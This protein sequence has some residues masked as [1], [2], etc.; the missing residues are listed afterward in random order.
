MKAKVSI[1][2]PVYNGANYMR[3]AIDSALAQSYE[4]TEIIVVNDG[5]VDNTEKIALSYGNKI[6]YFSK[7]NG[8]VSSALN[9]GIANMTGDYFQYLPHDDLLHPD[10]IK[11]QMEAIQKS[12]NRMSIAWSGWNRFLESSHKKLQFQIP[13]WYPRSCWT[14]RRYPLF[15]GILNTVT[16]LLHKR[17]FELVGTF[18]ETLR[19][20]QDYD[21]WFRTFGMNDTVY[22]DKP[23]VDYRIHEIQGT[24]SD[25]EFLKNCQNLAWKILQRITIDEIKKE[26]SSE[27]MCFYALMKYYH[28]VGWENHKLYVLQRFIE[29]EAPISAIKGRKQLSDEL[30]G[31]G[32]QLVL[33][34]AGKNGRRL[35]KELWAYGI[36]A[37]AFCDTNPS[38]TGSEIW[39]VKCIS[40]AELTD[41]DATII[42]TFD[43]PEQ[44]RKE[45][46]SQ[47]LTRV[48]DY[49]EE[50]EI[51]WRV[52]PIKERVLQL[53]QG[54]I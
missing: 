5:S 54:D 13:L 48:M 36:E 19:T 3:E 45:L 49:G 27:Y 30:C 21:M 15:F 23:L 37:S 17:Y 42:I 34:G 44:V 14:K 4:N 1:V 25:K 7:E 51:L 16:V 31:D 26:F 33:Y 40:K 50:A 6:R 46:L 9:V 8:G 24:Q 10:K 11:I 20:S 52:C 38:N 43:E 41:I 29:S 22:V 39:G 53:I 32:R 47:G 2:I 12:G 35:L 18:D 28:E